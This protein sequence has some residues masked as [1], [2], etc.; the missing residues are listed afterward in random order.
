MASSKNKKQKQTKNNKNKLL[1]NFLQHQQFAE[2]LTELSEPNRIPSSVMTTF[3]V[4]RSLV[5]MRL[6]L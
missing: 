5:L 1:K 2:I 4:I 3:S 6:Q